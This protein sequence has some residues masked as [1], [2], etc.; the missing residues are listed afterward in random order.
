MRSFLLDAV[1]AEL[2]SIEVDIGDV[3][4]RIVEQCK[5]LGIPA[6]VFTGI[7]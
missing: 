3:D 6:P 7:N 2:K 1:V 5:E 4:K